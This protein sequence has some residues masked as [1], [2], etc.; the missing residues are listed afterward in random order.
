MSE[1]TASH[2][3]IILALRR[4]G[5]TTLWRLFRQN[6]VFTCFDEPFSRLLHQLPKEH[7]KGVRKEFI[8]LYNENSALFH[9]IYAPILR[10]EETSKG[11]NEKQKHYLHF[12]LKKVPLVLDVTRCHGKI[13]DLHSE[14]PDAVFVHLYRRPASFVTSHLLPSDQKDILGLRSYWNRH[15]FFSKKKRFNRWGM[16]E[17]LRK[18]YAKITRK[19]IATEGVQLSPENS[20]A[21][22]LLLSHWLGCYRLAERKGTQFFGPR[23]LSV[24][25]EEFCANPKK[26]LTNI[27]KLAA[28]KSFDTDFSIIRKPS[29]PFQIE[30]PCWRRLA[31]EVGFNQQEISKFF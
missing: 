21:V 2:N 10:Q 30:D 15:V 28:A 8:D 5:T 11:M 19:L 13:S 26:I 4:S 22:R 7:K 25:F 20:S 14:M 1:E 9:K 27:Y 29:V 17:L 24:C 16:E 3:I 31:I 23:F 18:P 12:L 6:P